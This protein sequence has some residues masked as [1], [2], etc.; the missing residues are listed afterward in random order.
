MNVNSLP[1]VY[2][3]AQV[4]VIST[5]FLYLAVILCFPAYAYFDLKRQNA[6][7]YDLFFWKKAKNAAESQRVESQYLEHLL[8]DRFYKPMLLGEPS[9]RIIT[10]SFI[11]AVATLLLALGLY[12]IIQATVGIGLEDFL[13]ADHQ[14]HTW[15]SARSD[16]LGSWVVT[17]NWPAVNYTDSNVQ[18]RMIQQFEQVIGTPHIEEVDTRMLWIAGVFPSRMCFYLLLYELTSSGFQNLGCGLRAYAITT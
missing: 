18:M 6:R 3:T 10:H 17:M 16:I 5:I 9:I 7:R 2:L 4:A 15:A 14:G 1:A 8:Y 12:G 11:W 13:P